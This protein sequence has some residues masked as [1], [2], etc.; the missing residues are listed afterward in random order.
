MTEMD[1]VT[2]IKNFYCIKLKTVLAC[3]NM[4]FYKLMIDETNFGLIWKV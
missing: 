4:G 2:G 3:A 1:M